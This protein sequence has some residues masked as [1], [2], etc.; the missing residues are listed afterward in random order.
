M[1]ST[2]RVE[3]LVQRPFD[4]VDS[5]EIAVVQASGRDD[6]FGRALIRTLRKQG[7][8]GRVVPVNP[9]GRPRLG[10]P[11]CRSLREAPAG[12][13]GAIIAVPR[14]KLESVL[15]QCMERSI[16]VLA[17]ALTPAEDQGMRPADLTGAVPAGV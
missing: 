13:D 7:F 14:E 4:V 1:L 10:I 12:V 17:I 11:A 5:R 8:R 2:Q 3:I 9:D 6:G 15:A 16:H